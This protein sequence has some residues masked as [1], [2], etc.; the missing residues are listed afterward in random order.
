MLAYSSRFDYQKRHYQERLQQTVNSYD[1]HCSN[2][3][4]RSQ[5]NTLGSRENVFSARIVSIRG[6]DRD[7]DD[8]LRVDF[9]R[10]ISLLVKK[11][12]AEVE[13]DTLC[14]SAVS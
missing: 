8:H 7:V 12:D 9:V 3:S 14:C 10:F 4:R 6:F 11:L 5:F 13:P 1:K 2:R